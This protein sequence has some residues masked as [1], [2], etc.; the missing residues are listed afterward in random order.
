MNDYIELFIRLSKEKVNTLQSIEK[1]SDLGF[2]LT[3]FER[4]YKEG[5]VFLEKIRGK[6]KA[7]IMLDKYYVKLAPKGFASLES[8][9]NAESQNKVGKEV[10]NAT[11]II[12]I[13]TA[14]NVFVTLFVF[15]MNLESKNWATPISFLVLGLFIVTLAGWLATYCIRFMENKRYFKIKK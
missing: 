7:G 3:D 8:N 5:Y 1:F 11:I 6:N 4:L 9:F 15:I 2:F 14:L 10:L 12:A 13:A